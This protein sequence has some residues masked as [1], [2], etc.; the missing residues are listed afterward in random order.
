MSAWQISGYL[1]AFLAG[2]FVALVWAFRNLYAIGYG[3]ACG[4]HW[5]SI[6]GKVIA[7]TSGDDCYLR[8]EDVERLVK[9]TVRN[10]VWNEPK[11]AHQ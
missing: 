10:C 4:R 3:F 11:K 9:A 7:Q 1:F 6:N 2:V 5:M 8:D